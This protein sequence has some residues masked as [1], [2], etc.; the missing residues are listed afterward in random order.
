MITARTKGTV[1]IS[2]S[3]EEFLSTNSTAVALNF[4]SWHNGGCPIRNYSLKYRPLHTK[5]WKVVGTIKYNEVG[6]N[7]GGGGGHGEAVSTSS[8]SKPFIIGNLEPNREYSLA[9]TASSSAGLTE[10]VYNFS[11]WANGSFF[12]SASMGSG[13]VRLAGPPGLVHTVDISSSEYSSIGVSSPFHN[14]TILL[15]VVISV[16]VLAAVLTTLFAFMRKQQH[17]VMMVHA[18]GRRCSAR[19]T[20]SQS[21]AG[22]GTLGGGGGGGG[23]RSASLS[24]RS[25]ED[26]TSEMLSAA[27]PMTDYHSLCTGGGGGKGSNNKLVE[28]IGLN[29]MGGRGGDGHHLHNAHQLAANASEALYGKTMLSSCQTMGGYASPK[30]TLLCGEN[31]GNGAQGG[32]GGDQQMV[33]GR[34]STRVTVNSHHIYAEPNPNGLMMQTYATP[35]C[36]LTTVAPGGGGGGGGGGDKSCQL[37]DTSD[38]FSNGGLLSMALQQPPGQLMS[39]NE[40]TTTTF[41]ALI[42]NTPNTNNNNN[43]NAHI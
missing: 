21:T 29:G 42:T 36:L 32:G 24:M 7:G 25:K 3:A 4:N 28:A 19:S 40:T 23:L 17:G 41:R 34:P 18:D 37:L 5:L 14:V 16:L 33:M 30:R 1:A 43:N 8:F 6:G 2:P 22:A 39:S 26:I 35:R 13:V 20:N 15:P 9:V 38:S 12:S 27:F 31:N 10:A 11:T